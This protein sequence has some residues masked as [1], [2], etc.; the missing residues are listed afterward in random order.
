[1]YISEKPSILNEYSTYN[2][3]SLYNSSTRGS[4]GQNGSHIHHRFYNEQYF[5][6]YSDCMCHNILF[7]LSRWKLKVESPLHGITKSK[8]QHTLCG[9]YL[10]STSLYSSLYLGLFIQKYYDY[11]RFCQYYNDHTDD[12]WCCD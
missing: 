11:S 1:M 8:S 6:S 7:S 12:C 4:D 3:F 2:F 9:I 10:S 5:D